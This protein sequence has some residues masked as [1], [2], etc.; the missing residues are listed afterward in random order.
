[1]EGSDTTLTPHQ[2]HVR[3]VAHTPITAPDL[4]CYER[5]A[6]G[7]GAVHRAGAVWFGCKSGVPVGISRCW[8]LLF[9]RWRAAEV[10]TR[11]SQVV[12]NVVG[13][14]EIR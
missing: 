6:C 10:V 4:G 14:R 12:R 2:S 5:L 13:P 7:G 9:G 1:M 8:D 3:G 11:L